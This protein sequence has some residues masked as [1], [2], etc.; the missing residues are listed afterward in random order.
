MVTDYC[1]DAA[2]IA[3][4]NQKNSQ[5]GYISFT[6]GRELTDIPNYPGKPNIQNENA[7]DI[8][9]L[10]SARNFLYLLNS[11]KFGS[12][13]AFLQAVQDTNYDAVIIDK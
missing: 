8:N 6:A 13:R 2:K 1:S 10:S 9:D 11:E 12:K 7:Y 4:S 5:R 3:D